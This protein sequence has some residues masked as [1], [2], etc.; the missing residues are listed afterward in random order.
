MNNIERE[1]FLFVFIS[2]KKAKTHAA[3]KMC[4]IMK[5]LENE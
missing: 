1:K 5:Y 4:K 2:N 3:Y